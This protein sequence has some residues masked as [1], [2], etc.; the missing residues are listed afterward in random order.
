[1]NFV[2]VDEQV[3]EYFVANDIQLS[4]DASS[5][6][7]PNFNQKFAQLKDI[8]KE[9]NLEVSKLNTTDWHHLKL[10][11]FLETDCAETRAI[12]FEQFNQYAARNG[13]DLICLNLKSN[14]Q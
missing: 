11:I 5:T 12:K 13:G 3:G 7:Q 2:D 9:R 6:H 4:V 10:L 14:V 1:M 8:V